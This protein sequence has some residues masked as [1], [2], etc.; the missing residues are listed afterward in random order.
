MKHL[1]IAF[2]STA[3]MAATPTVKTQKPAAAPSAKNIDLGHFEV[4]GSASL[5]SG[6]GTT[7][8][9]LHPNLEYFVARGISVGGTIGLDSAENYSSLGLGPSATWYFAESGPMAFYAAQA[10]ALSN[11][12]LNNQSFN[13]TYGVTSAG[14][15]FFVDPKVAIGTGLN[16]HYKISDDNQAASSGTANLLADF[17]IYF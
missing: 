5:S 17:H 14:M 11:Y 2:I 15:R 10:L 12:R 1:L 16:F 8:L 7:A 13:S 3:A 4:G 6:R 9:N